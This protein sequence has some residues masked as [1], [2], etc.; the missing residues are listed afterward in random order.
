LRLEA[1]VL[2]AE[3]GKDRRKRKEVGM[4]P[5]AHR[6]LHLRPGGKGEKKELL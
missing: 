2:K 1:K 3:S 5:P 4:R 6:G